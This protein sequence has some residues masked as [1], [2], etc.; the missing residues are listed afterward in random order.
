[1]TSTYFCTQHVELKLQFQ[2]LF[3]VLSSIGSVQRYFSRGHTG[4][5]CNVKRV[6]ETTYASCFSAYFT[7]SF[8]PFR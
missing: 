6:S 2:L 1:M 3:S 8:F 4:K 5:S 7:I